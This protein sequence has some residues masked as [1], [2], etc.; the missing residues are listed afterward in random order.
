[1]G[2]TLLRDGVQLFAARRKSLSHAN[3]EPYDL[4]MN[5]LLIG[6]TIF[7]GR[8]VVDAALARGHRL[9]LFN[10]GQHNPELFPDVEKLRGDRNSDLSALHGRR[11][12]AVID[13]CGYTPKQMHSMANALGDDVPRYVFV[14]SVSAYGSRAPF[15]SYDET[16]PLAVGDTGYGEEKARAEEAIAARYADRVA[17]VRPGLIVGP[18]DPTGRF[19]YWPMRAQRGGDVLAP[20]RPDRPI[21]WIDVRDLAD[22]MVHLAE[23]KNQGA[24][25][26]ITQA[27]Q[28]TM[29]DLLESCVRLTQKNVTMH[30]LDD[31]RL[32]NANV[33]PWTELP[34]WIPEDEPD[35]G[36][37]MLA[38][39]NRAID[40]GLK[41]RSIDDTLRDTLA[42][43]QQLRG[44][45]AALGTNKTLAPSREAE[46]L[47]LFNFIT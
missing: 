24:F 11:F 35:A 44:D 5:I 20:G 26:A 42:W 41:F 30:W 15:D 16:A 27:K 25:N 32:F 14:S 19:V 12:D 17:I 43:T 18:H 33:A 13:V 21:Q 8:H 1:L 9:T 2:E 46:L 6:G 10:R 36:G 34:L 29:S 45:D 37:L 23:H 38:K 3:R 28:H 47:R 7:L 40:A 39:A 22:W 31:S 4:R